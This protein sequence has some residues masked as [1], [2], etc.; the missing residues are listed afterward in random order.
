MRTLIFALVVFMACSKEGHVELIAPV[1]I[2]GHWVG[3]NEIFGTKLVVEFEILQD[4]DRVT[5][6]MG[7]YNSS[8]QLMEGSC[9]NGDSAIFVVDYGYGE[10]DFVFKG[11]IDG[12]SHIGGMYFI[13]GHEE[14]RPP[15]SERFEIYRDE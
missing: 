9:I 4:E 14:S 1:D 2:T 15:R 13:D 3:Y 6:E 7:F 10:T 8:M 12:E 11:R 5:G